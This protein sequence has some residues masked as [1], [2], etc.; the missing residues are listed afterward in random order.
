MSFKFNRRKIKYVVKPEEKMVIGW[1][2]MCDSDNNDI[3]SV[4][5]ELKDNYYF[6]LSALKVEDIWQQDE[7][8]L[9]AVSR[10]DDR[11]E[12]DEKIGKKIVAD[13][14]EKKY[15]ILMMKKYK[16][17]ERKLNG[18]LDNTYEL[19]MMHENRLRELQAR[20]NKYNEE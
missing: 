10:C 20:I 15:H 17:I 16:Q 12:F 3:T 19:G 8:I 9:K 7:R 6:L 18:I 13:I 11:D 14:L 4:G 1:I 5:W 2:N